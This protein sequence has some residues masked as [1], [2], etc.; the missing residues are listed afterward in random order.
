M[1]GEGG[2]KSTEKLE[3]E[4]DTVVDDAS[5]ELKMQGDRTSFRGVAVK[6]VKLPSMVWESSGSAIR[7][8]G[9][10]VG[11]IKAD[12]YYETYEKD[13]RGMK[14]PTSDLVITRLHVDTVVG[15]TDSG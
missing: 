14:L 8:H 2:E 6:S 1:I 13:V 10:S 12:G 4:I 3:R 5:G 7:G 9:V 15:G 11:G